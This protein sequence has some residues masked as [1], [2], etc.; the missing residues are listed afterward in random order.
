MQSRSTFWLAAVALLVAVVALPVALVAAIRSGHGSS[1]PTA[2]SSTG[3]MSMGGSSMSD[4]MA[5]APTDGVPNAT[6]NV[7]GTP[8]AHT[9]AG[10]VWVFRLDAKPVR[11]RSCQAGV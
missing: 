1:T 7:G 2:G 11:W 5:P 3:G 9:V 6:A 4:H 10:G 8:L